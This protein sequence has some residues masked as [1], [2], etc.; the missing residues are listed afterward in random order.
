MSE[1]TKTLVHLVRHG[2]VE[3]PTG[4]LYGR[5]PGFHLS[6]V[7]REMADRVAEFVKG[8]DVTHLRCSPLERAQETMAP[9]KAEFNLPVITDGRV[10]EAENYL[11]G[12]RFDSSKNSAFTNPKHWLY[13]RNPLKPTWGEPYG[14]IASRMQAAI[15]EAADAAVG[16]QAVIVSHQLPIWVARL[17]VEG[18]RFPHDPRKRQ[19]SLA[20]VTT[21]IFR[22]RR[23]TGIEYQEPAA[24]LVP[25]ARAKKFVAGA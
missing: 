3:N 11:Q 21:F 18:R 14:E 9:I 8:W 16:H 24:D 2:L 7:G 17:A 23:I 10:I 12:H 22:D 5:L 20:S 15:Q 19:C 25:G 6:E 4:V 13:F 1:Q